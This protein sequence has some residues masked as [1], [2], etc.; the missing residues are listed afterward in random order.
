MLTQ[1]ENRKDLGFGTKI[2]SERV[3]LINKDGTFNVRR[4]GDSFLNSVNWYHRLITLSWGK[5]FGI[6]FLFYFLLNIIFASLYLLIGIEYLE[7]VSNEHQQ[8]PFWEAFFFSA[9][10]LTTVGY[11]RISPSGFWTNGIAAFEALVGLLLIALATGLLYGRFS[12]SVPKI[13]FSKNIVLAP[14]LDINGL[15]FRIIHERDNELIDLD[16]E[17]TLSCLD[18]LPSGART[19]KY[20]PLDL[21]RDHVNFFPLN[22]TLVHPITEDSPLAKA[23]EKSLAEADAEFLIMIRAIDETFMQQVHVRFSYHYVELLW[24]AKFE[25]MFDTSSQ[26]DIAVRVSDIDRYQLASLNS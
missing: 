2:T 26:G 24:G 18:T 11:G 7:G 4:V 5:F 19:R 13:R 17:M 8:P 10:T 9:Q 20:Y 23:T 14:Y 25:P 6:V 1:E 22:W 12:R 15:M 3:R 21:E 16:V